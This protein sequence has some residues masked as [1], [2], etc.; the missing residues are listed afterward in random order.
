MTIP[1]IT[2]KQREIP[3]L[4]YRF[5]FLH[6]NHIRVLMHHKDKRRINEW[7]KDLVKKSYIVT[8]VNDISLDKSRDS[9]FGYINTQTKPVVYRLGINGV[10][11]LKTQEGIDFGVDVAFLHKFYRENIRS[12]EF[13]AQSLFL[14]DIHGQLMVNMTKEDK[15]VFYTKS[16]YSPAESSYSCLTEV[17]PDA[18]IQKRIGKG[19]TKQYLLHI[20]PESMLRTRS[21]LLHKTIKAYFEFYFQSKWENNTNTSLPILLFILPDMQALINLQRY[22]QT[23]LNEN[24]NPDIHFWLATRKQIQREGFSNVN[25]EVVK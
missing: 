23:K 24:D 7:L 15:L 2:N 4:L 9:N 3:K 11:F 12:D 17:S 10:R 1:Y 5:R 25:W 20:V 22:I 14:A 21:Y 18:F 16:D 8:I 13:I 6:S 19:K